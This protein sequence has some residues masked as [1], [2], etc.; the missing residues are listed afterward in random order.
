M[1]VVEKGGEGAVGESESLLLRAWST[2]SVLGEAAGERGACSLTQ[3]HQDRNQS[4][5]QHHWVRLLQ[6]LHDVPHC[7][8]LGPLE[9]WKEGSADRP[10]PPMGCRR[11]CAMRALQAVPIVVDV[12]V[13]D[14]AFTSPKL[15]PC[16]C[17]TFLPGDPLY[18]TEA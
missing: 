5:R 18:F 17:L 7:W 9:G 6:R 12:S 15:G 8:E 3:E 1:E 2:G 10:S 4:Y 13:C 11:H 14:S 16:Q